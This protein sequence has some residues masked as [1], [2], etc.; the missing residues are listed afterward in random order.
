MQ[1]NGWNKSVFLVDGWFKTDEAKGFWDS[2]I[3]N[4]VDVKLAIYLKVS[5][6]TM[7]ARVLKRNDRDSDNEKV[8]EKRVNTFNNNT[9]L[10]YE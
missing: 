4:I 9:L 8:A 7:K 6:E 10:V 2:E 1:E 3:K 5:P